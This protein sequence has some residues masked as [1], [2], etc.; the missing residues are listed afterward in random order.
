MLIIT[1]IVNLTFPENAAFQNSVLSVC[2]SIN[3][4]H[5]VIQH[6]LTPHYKI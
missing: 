5:K 3:V 1:F 2:I 6:S 4:E